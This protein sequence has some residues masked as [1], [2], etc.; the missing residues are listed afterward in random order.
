ME[1]RNLLRKLCKMLTG[2]YRN[3]IRH[4]K[5]QKENLQRI[6]LVINLLEIQRAKLTGYQSVSQLKESN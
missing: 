4:F 2:G 6:S 5:S 3:V 1:S